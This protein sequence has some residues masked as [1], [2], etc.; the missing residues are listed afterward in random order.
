MA[1]DWREAREQ[2]DPLA[3]IETRRRQAVRLS[4]P[5]PAWAVLATMVYVVATFALQ[6]FPGRRLTVPLGYTIAVI[7]LTIVLLRWRLRRATL[8]SSLRWLGW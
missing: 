8:H 6:D 2:I 1:E 3:E 4:D 5:L 7:P